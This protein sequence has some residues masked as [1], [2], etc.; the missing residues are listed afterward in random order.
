MVLS[1]QGKCCEQNASLTLEL[2]VFSPIRSAKVCTKQKNLGN[3]YAPFQL[4]HK[5]NSTLQILETI[6]NTLGE[7]CL[8]QSSIN[9]STLRLICYRLN[10]CLSLTSL[11]T[12]YKSKSCREVK[13]A[14]VF[15]VFSNFLWLFV[16]LQLL[17]KGIRLSAFGNMLLL[18]FIFFTGRRKRG[19]SG[20]GATT[21]LKWIYTAFA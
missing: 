21:S 16:Y 19:C 1:L 5:E 12:Q 14:P 7:E 18:F 20:V 6:F 3:N 4:K 15:Q 9:N 11:A 17:F 10:L 8:H 2:F 13:H